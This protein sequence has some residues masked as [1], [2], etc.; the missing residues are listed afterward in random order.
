MERCLFGTRKNRWCRLTLLTFVFFSTYTDDVC[1]LSHAACCMFVYICQASVVSV[2][3]CVC[4]IIRKLT[5]CMRSVKHLRLPQ[6]IVLFLE[7]A[8][9]NA[10][11]N[12]ESDSVF[13]VYA[14]AGAIISD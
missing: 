9:S 12:D 11:L 10:F 13:I 6:L 8:F 1:V 4:I 3:V 14:P 7:R 5:V 2:Y